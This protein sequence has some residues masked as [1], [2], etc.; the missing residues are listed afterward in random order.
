QR[1][2][3]Y[4]G[5]TVLTTN[6]RGNV[7]EAFARRFAFTV[8]F[9]T[10]DAA[11]RARIWRVALPLHVPLAEDVDL[12]QLAEWID[13]TGSGIANAASAAASLAAAEDQPIAR[14]HLVRGIGRELQKSG[15]TP[16]RAAFGS[17][18]R[19]LVEP[20]EVTDSLSVGPAP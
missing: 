17:Y 19:Y 2:E 20:S 18:Y 13:L 11:L 16:P 9:P 15:R 1:M 7:D 14:R 8:D 5:L 6:L 10:P 3:A 4:D 12:D